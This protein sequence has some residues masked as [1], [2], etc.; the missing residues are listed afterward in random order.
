MILETN[1]AVVPVCIDGMDK[2]LPIGA[3]FPR[4][5]KKIYIRFGKPIDLSEFRD[6]EKNRETAKL[7]MQKVMD[8]I[9]KLKEEIKA[10]QKNA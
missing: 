1:P 9:R 6:R 7:V 10:A 3:S 8:N 4:I 5:F 2:V